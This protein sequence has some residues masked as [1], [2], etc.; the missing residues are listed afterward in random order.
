MRN[1]ANLP[2]GTIERF[3]MENRET[4]LVIDQKVTIPLAEI[5]FEFV[6]SSGPGG[7]NVN[8]VNSQAQLHWNVNETE[9][10]PQVVKDRLRLREANRINKE[11]VLRIDCQTCRDREKNRQECLN[12]L[13]EI[14]V[15][16]LVVPKPRK[17]RRPPR[18]VKEKRLQNKKERS[19]VKR[20]RRP[21]S[22]ND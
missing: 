20:L 14:I 6:R 16:A 8:K 22:M 12:R 10:L 17:K 15:R 1:R 13:R 9:S 5:R 3:S 11:G 21:P 18:W 2:V 19:K 4:Q 7:Q